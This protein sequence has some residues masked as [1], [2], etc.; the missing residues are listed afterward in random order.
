MNPLLVISRLEADYPGRARVL[1]G[2]DLTVGAGE[3]VGLAG[4]SGCGKSTLALAIPRLLAWRNARTRGSIVYR[5][6][7]LTAL[8]ERELR[9]IRGR[10]IALVWQSPVAALNPALRIGTQLREAWRAHSDSRGWRGP[11]LETLASVSLPAEEDF[12]RRYPGELSVGLAQRVVIAM[13]LL[14]RPSLLIADEATSALD[15][16]TQSEI[17]RLFADLNRRLGLAILYI[18]HDLLSVASICHRVAI[19]E[20]GAIVECGPSERIFQSPEHP[21]TRRL[22]EALPRAPLESSWSR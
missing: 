7:E 16:I 8:G 2:V 9:A 18:S 13:A 22:I 5:G 20:E 12:L 21:Y 11:V 10:E 15:A 3:I 14:H 19:L 17:L 4:R 1:A 6:R